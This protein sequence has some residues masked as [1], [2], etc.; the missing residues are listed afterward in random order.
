MAE[1]PRAMTQ[2]EIDALFAS[3][4]GSQ[5]S[6]PKVTPV[7]KPSADAAKDEAP[8]EQDPK[9]SPDGSD[10]QPAA[11]EEG[12]DMGQDDIDALVSQMQGEDAPAEEEAPAEG[13]A[14]GGDMGQ[15][16][17]DAL[18]AEMQGDDADGNDDAA[19]PAADDGASLGQDDIDALLQEMNGDDEPAADEG[20]SLGQDDIDA[21]LAELNDDPSEQPATQGDSQASGSATSVSKPSE[22]GDDGSLGQDDIDALLA[23]M[24][25][26][27]V[28]PVSDSISRSDSDSASR[29]VTQRAATDLSQEE[30]DS[31]V[32]K[33]SN[34]RDDSEELISQDD[35]DL[36][37]RQMSEATGSSDSEHLTAMVNRRENDI[38]ALLNEASEHA[39]MDDAVSDLGPFARQSPHESMPMAPVGAM[40][41]EELRGT[42]FLLTA[43]VFLL[44]M[45]T[46]AM[47]FVVSSIT[48]LSTDLRDSRDTAVAP[49]DDYRE[50][51]RIALEMMADE[52]PV[53]AQK[54]VKLMERV[55]RR[56]RDI[57][58]EIEVS[59]H[60]ARHHYQ[61][62]HYEQA[63]EEFR[64][65]ANRKGGLYDDPQF[66]LQWAASQDALGQSQR[67]RQTV[68]VLLAN[69]AFFLNDAD[70]EPLSGERL[71]QR[72]RMIRQAHLLLGRL[73]LG[74]F[75]DDDALSS[76]HVTGG[77]S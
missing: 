16:D 37:V 14:E 34:D 74:E 53:D 55:R 7:D 3:L 15:D 31:L 1:E 38:E 22:S 42:R 69:E 72:Q 64:Q 49:T 12:G 20:A 18:V 48:R 29:P 41:P 66:Y 36:L 33:H 2:E 30:I 44:A 26:G 57:D 35:I 23:E 9:P 5:P 4:S 77:G 70:G 51:L 62:G 61:R 19:A 39:D 65:V 21:L 13:A 50:D 43:A 6:V 73:D 52:N 25:G 45:C 71:E 27:D 28:A 8:A 40:V 32:N 63:N 17:I 46:V 11:A 60:L 47:V 54:G 68:G 24:A 67:A 59:L 76:V 58:K 75:L 10:S 56:H